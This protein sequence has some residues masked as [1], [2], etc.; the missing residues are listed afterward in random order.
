MLFS[1]ARPLRYR[2]LN[3][4]CGLVES[5]GAYLTLGYVRSLP[6]AARTRPPLSI[7]RSVY[8]RYPV[9]VLLFQ[10]QHVRYQI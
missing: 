2:H 6:E 1:T 3:I 8:S 10:A 5:S 9:I 4:V 7:K